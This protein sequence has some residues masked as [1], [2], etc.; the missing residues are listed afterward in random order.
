M[1]TE[2][3]VNFLMAPESLFAIATAVAGVLVFSLAPYLPSIFPPAF[4]RLVGFCAVGA[5]LAPL[6]AL[7]ES[8]QLPAVVGACSLMIMLIVHLAQTRYTRRA[9]AEHEADAE[10]P[11]H[12]PTC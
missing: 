1:A 4:I 10:R 2:N 9:S 3:V 5:S 8:W 6:W 12:S 7:S 11:E